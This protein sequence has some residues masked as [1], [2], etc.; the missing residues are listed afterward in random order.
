MKAFVFPGQGAQFK[1]M[2]SQWLDRFGSM[3]R[4]ADEILG[5]SLKDMCLAD[6]GRKLGLTQYTQP[7]L[8]VVGAF[9]YQARREDGDSAPAF[10]AGHSLGEYCA[11]YAAGVFDFA[12]GLRLVQKRGEL[13]SRAAQGAMAAVIGMPPAD[14]E[15]LLA[16][17]GLSRVHVANINTPSQVVISGDQ[18]EIAAAQQ[19]FE[20]VPNVRFTRLN[21]SGAF[22]SPLM[23]QARDEFAGFCQRFTFRDP[24]VPVV[25]N[26]TARPYEAGQVERLLVEQI[27]SPVQWCDSVRYLLA[28][29]V[30][31]LVELGAGQILT[32]LIVQIRA[33]APAMVLPPPATEPQITVPAVEVPVQQALR[34]D[35]ESVVSAEAGARAVEVAAEASASH[36][37]VPAPT[38]RDMPA[39]ATGCG[40][41]V[42]ATMLGSA[43]FR[44]DYNIKYAY[45]AGSMYKGIASR[46]LVVRMGKAG[47]LGFLG[48]GGMS[49]TEVEN[50]LRYIQH[51]LKDGFSYGCNV[52]HS[53]AFLQAE[54]DVVDLLLKLG[55]CNVEASAFMQITPALVRYKLQ[56]LSRAADGSVISRHRIIAKISHMEVAKAFLAPPPDRIVQALLESGRITAE[57][58]QLAAQVPMADDLCVEADSGGHTDQGVAYALFPAIAALRDEIMSQRRY[59]KPVRVGAAGGIGTPHAAMAAF[60]LGADFIVTGSINQCSVEAGTSEAVKDMLQDLGVNDTDYAPAGDMFEVG[61]KVQVMKKGVFFPARA[62]KLYDLYRQHASLDEIDARTRKQL[63][64][65]YFK[66][67]FEQVWEETQAYYRRKNPAEIE[68]AL[69][70]PKH[71]MSLVFRWYF[72]HTTRVALAGDTAQ[73]VDFQ[74]H[75]G[76][77]LGAFNQWV[78]GTSLENWRNRHVDTMALALLKSTA[79]LVTQALHRYAG[80]MPAG[81]ERE[82]EPAPLRRPLLASV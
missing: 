51:E 59:A 45:L 53:P 54:E 4:E 82:L 40:A 28:R 60:M 9:A 42:D 30:T 61:A 15:G 21:V 69:Q 65:K 76:P 72:V 64:D 32:R 10:A 55:V 37:H 38:L 12:T 62:N 24:T 57:Q 41:G 49:V 35:A 19:H 3:V 23:R 70:S 63:E 14:I 77:A 52:L 74:V 47:L 29:G 6:P 43:E 58:S 78:K 36:V 80:S 31:D 56:G 44:R 2:G 8:Y 18:Q 25:A 34:A 5:Y 26:V 46:D 33:E 1:G 68:R 50:D 27:T 16:R 67:S 79:E 20:A 17:H 11:L 39:T 75:C 22:H 71:K 81:P 48:S 7:A 73:R 13:M 66:R